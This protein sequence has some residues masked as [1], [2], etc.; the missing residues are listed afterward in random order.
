[1][2]TREKLSEY[3]DEGYSLTRIAKETGYHV[4]YISKLCKDF[5]L[6]APL[7]GRKPGDIQTEETKAKIAESLRKKR[8][9]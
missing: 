1:M 5:Q 8:E 2:I 3:L 9:G 6:K 7:P 4:S